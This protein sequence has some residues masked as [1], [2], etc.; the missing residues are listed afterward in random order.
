MH[1]NSG[2]ALSRLILNEIIVSPLFNQQCHYCSHVMAF[3]EDL[4]SMPSWMPLVV[5][6]QDKAGFMVC[7]PGGLRVCL[8]ETSQ[9]ARSMSIKTVSGIR[10]HPPPYRE[11]LRERSPKCCQEKSI[12]IRRRCREFA[13]PV[14]AWSRLNGNGFAPRNVR[15]FFKHVNHE[16]L[17]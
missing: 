13:M 1:V 2:I 15:L 14:P 9:I 8:G 11:T 6:K 10:I 16:F 7:C 3:R 12:I 5:E 4:K 17:H